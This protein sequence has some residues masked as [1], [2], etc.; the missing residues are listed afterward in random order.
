MAGLVIENVVP[1]SIAEEMEIE[2]GDRLLAVNGQ[3]IRD[4]LDY[5]YF[6]GDE[7]VLLEIGKPD[8]EV[9]D[10]EVERDEG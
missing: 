3:P 4:I 2:A 7:Q 6:S 10:V 9:W 1:G 8:G 5:N